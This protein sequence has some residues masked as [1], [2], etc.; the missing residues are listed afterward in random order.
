MFACALLAIGAWELAHLAGA[1]AIA[2]LVALVC[3]AFLWRTVERTRTW[4]D[5]F[6]F[7]RE[8]VRTAPRSAKAHGNMALALVEIGD[9]RGAIE[10]YRRAL[11]IL[12]KYPRTWYLLGNALHR[13]KENPEAIIGAYRQTILLDPTHVDARVNLAVTLLDLGRAEEARTLVAEIRALDPDHPWLA[14]LARRSVED[15]ASRPAPR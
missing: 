7:Y 10:E 4:S 15:G 3:A 12:P 11:A 8:Q 5:N 14:E 2:V 6:T 13:L 9:D 1:R